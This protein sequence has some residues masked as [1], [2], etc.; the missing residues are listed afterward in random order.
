M[1]ESFSNLISPTQCITNFGDSQD[2][3]L[4]TWPPSV[5][6]AHKEARQ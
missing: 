3:P 2:L 6:T 1:F 4:M 5:V